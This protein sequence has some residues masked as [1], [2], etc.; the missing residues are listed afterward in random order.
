MEIVLGVATLICGIA[1]LWFFWDKIAPRLRRT[2]PPSPPAPTDRST[3]DRAAIENV[4]QELETNAQLLAARQY[5]TA[6]ALRDDVWRLLEPGA[7]IPAALRTRLQ[8]IYA[9]IRSAKAIH[10]SFRR[11]PAIPCQNSSR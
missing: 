5:A 11:R 4:M 10:R 1:A 2:S 7:A 9:N 3:H 6:L 8:D